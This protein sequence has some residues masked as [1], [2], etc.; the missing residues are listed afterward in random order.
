METSTVQ[1]SL[2]RRILATLVW[3]VHIG[4]IALVLTAWMLPVPSLW[5]TVGLLSPCLQIQWSLNEGQ[6]VLTTLE[7][8]LLEVPNA[9]DPIQASFTGR[10]LKPVFGELPPRTVDMICYGVN[11]ICWGAS[12]L[13]LAVHA[14]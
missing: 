12:L 3:A 5:W 2:P 11:G 10:L 14:V 13:R 9:G 1:P 8:W 6:C 7:H 4:V